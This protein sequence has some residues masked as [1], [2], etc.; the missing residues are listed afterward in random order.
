[1]L[2]TKNLQLGTL[3]LALCTDVFSIEQFQGNRCLLHVPLFWILF[4][5]TQFFKIMFHLQLLQN[6]GNISYVVQSILV[7]CLIPNSLYPL[8]SPLLYCHSPA[9]VTTTLLSISVSLL[10]CLL[11]SL[12]CCIFNFIF[13]YVFIYLLHWILAAVHRIYDLHWCMQILFFFFCS[14]WNLLVGAFKL[15]SCCMLTLSYCIQDLVT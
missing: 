12:V 15:F 5:L 4:F 9:L 11:Y 7:A 6:I 14:M 2:N 10:P 8:T 3:K 13:K 1:M